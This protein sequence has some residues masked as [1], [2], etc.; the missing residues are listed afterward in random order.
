MRRRIL[1][2]PLRFYLI[3]DPHY[4][5]ISLGAEGEAYE[6]RSLTDQ[7]CIAETGAIIDSAFTR[8]AADTET[9][10]VLIAG[11]LTFN[12][13]AASHR[14]ML[15]KLDALAAGGKRI[16]VITG[17]HDG[18]HEAYAFSGAKRFPVEETPREA[19]WD[20]YYEHGIKDAV[21]ADRGRMCY[22]ARLG[23]GVRLLG[24][25]YNLDKRNGG[26]EDSMDW[27]L[28]QIAQAKASGDL[29]FAMNHVPVLPG[30]PVLAG[31]GDAMLKGWKRIAET[32][33]DAGL[34]LIF[35]G[36]MHMQ[37]VNKL[38]TE[39]GNFIY[40]ICTG[41]LAGGPCAIRKISIDEN[42]VMRIASS[43]VEDFDW[44]KNGLTAGE[45]FTWRFNR[46]IGHE[47][48]SRRVGR[49]AARMLQGVTLGKLARMLFFEAD[50]SLVDRNLLEF[51]V[52]LIR[53]IFY[54][55]QPYT[56]GTPEHAYAMRLLGR[57][58]PVVWLAGK[59]LKQDIPSLAAAIMGKEMKIDYTAV[60]DLKNGGASA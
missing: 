55:D 19:L 56:E 44:D 1:K 43:T 9:D 53:N 5:D 24:I 60:I 42:W 21:A 12:G 17:N 35:T 29:I 36:H 34:P 27:M 15:E 18:S 54:G 47:I 45:Y 8:I 30:S 49:L 23:E 4:F 52:E 14:R 3:A 7:K 22:V 2:E 59:R 25:N 46:K 58:R 28:E 39:S 26:F 16:Y 31:E 37:S 48:A 13:E 38:V 57:L 33:A 41:S 40:D 20:L 6:A 51:V 32:L 11:D 50:A 10:I